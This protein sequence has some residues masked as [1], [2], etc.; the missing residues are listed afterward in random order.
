MANDDLEIEITEDT[1][2]EDGYGTVGNIVTKMMLDRIL[3]EDEQKEYRQELKKKDGKKYK[4][5]L[6]YE[7]Q[8]DKYK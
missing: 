3:D 4:E 6:E 8:F 5:F 7:K 2:E 1:F